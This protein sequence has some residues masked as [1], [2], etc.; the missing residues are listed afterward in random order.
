MGKNMLKAPLIKSAVLLSVIMLLVYLTA[1]SPDGSVWASLGQILL[2]VFRA[3]QLTVGLILALGICFL[4]LAGIFLGGLTLI[5]KES[6]VRLFQKLCGCI[7]AKWHAGISLL[8][9]GER[10]TTEKKQDEPRLRQQEEFAADLQLSLEQLR[11]RLDE[12]EAVGRGMEERMAA[13]EGDTAA[14]TLA[15]RLDGLEKRVGELAAYA[16]QVG[17]DL[18]QMQADF[19]ELQKQEKTRQNEGVL[20]TLNDRVTQLEQE[21]EALGRQAGPDAGEKGKGEDDTPGHRLYAYID[22]TAAQRQLEELVE[23][24]VKQD[25]TYA[26]ATDYLLEHSDAAVAD[27]LASHPS[28]T[29]EFIRLHRQQG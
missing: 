4:V 21:L 16:E 3:A 25:M 28:L 11:R 2:A 7:A 17:S 10:G 15:E 22:D 26:E 12:H 19:S 23:Y 20:S 9:G 5:S 8:R 13:L 6:G 29:K 14:R 1:S 18:R 24:T 27:V